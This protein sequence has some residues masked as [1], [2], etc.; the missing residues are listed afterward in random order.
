MKTK[1]LISLLCVAILSTAAFANSDTKAAKFAAETEN[2]K[3]SVSEWAMSVA[4]SR[5]NALNTYY[6]AR[7]VVD[8]AYWET[9]KSDRQC[10]N[11]KIRMVNTSSVAVTI[12]DITLDF[13]D[14][15]GRQLMNDL[16][17]KSADLAPGD[18]EG[19][20]FQ[21]YAESFKQHQQTATSGQMSLQ[22]GSRILVDDVNKGKGNLKPTGEPFVVPRPRDPFWLGQKEI[23]FIV[24]SAEMGAGVYDQNVK[25]PE[26]GWWPIPGVDGSHSMKTRGTM[27]KAG[28][29]IYKEHPSYL[30]NNDVGTTAQAP[31]KEEGATMQDGLD[32]VNTTADTVKTV[33]GA[34]DALKGLSSIFN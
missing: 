3:L 7:I 16:T 9:T 17:H 33:K 14:A 12:T 29:V 21:F 6:G 4:A 11:L 28:P 19:F 13:R 24:G 15:T 2:Y 34:V 8:E 20:H 18:A 10:L 26:R 1:C 25:F 5:I 27:A 32:A 23:D 31:A 22:F 30:N